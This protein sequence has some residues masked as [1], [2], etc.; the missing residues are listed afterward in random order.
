MAG[1]HEGDCEL[2]VLADLIR[3][4][5]LAIFARSNMECLALAWPW[6][7]DWRTIFFFFGHL[8]PNGDS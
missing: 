2:S 5:G 7:G 6:L 1:C 3:L 8:M 4:L